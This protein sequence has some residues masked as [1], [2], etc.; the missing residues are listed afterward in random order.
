MTDEK[1]E[2]IEN[3]KCLPEKYSP[4]QKQHCS[5]CLAA[6]DFWSENLEEVD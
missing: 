5:R 3:L 6:G 2:G 4:P 1:F